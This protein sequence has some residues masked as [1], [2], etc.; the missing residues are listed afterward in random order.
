M[1]EEKIE[2]L[3]RQTKH[4]RGHLW[5]IHYVTISQVIAIV[6]FRSDDFN[7]TIRNT[8]FTNFLVSS[9]P[10]SRK[11]WKTHKLLID[12]LIDW[13]ISAISWLKLLNIESTKK[14]V[15]LMQ[16]YKC[17]ILKHM[18]HGLTNLDSFEFDCCLICL[19]YINITFIHIPLYSYI[20]H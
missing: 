14:Y 12:C 17:C 10:L 5:Y 2:L 3:L 16:V 1:N 8:W 18:F 7:F 4:I 19:L 11:S 13:C 20:K 9:N 15:L 6:N